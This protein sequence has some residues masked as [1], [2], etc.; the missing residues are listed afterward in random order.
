MSREEAEAAL[1]DW[2]DAGGFEGDK[3]LGILSTEKGRQIF[4]ESR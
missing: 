2:V 3:K 4:P 1:K